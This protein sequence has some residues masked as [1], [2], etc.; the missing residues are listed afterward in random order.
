MPRTAL[1]LAGGL[2]TRIRHLAPN[3]PKPM[4]AVAG[5]PFLEWVIGYWRTQGVTRFAVSLGHMA[6]AAQSYLAMRPLDGMEIV[7]VHEPEPMGT[8]GAVRFAAARV[9][10]GDTFVTA[11]ADSLVVADTSPAWRLMEQEAAIDGVV[12]GVRVEDASRYGTLA[13]DGQGLLTEFREKAPGAGL[14]NAGVYFFRRRMLARFGDKTPLSMENDVFP[15][16]IR[17]G[18]RLHVLGV[19][20]P[21]LDIGTPESLARAGAFVTSW[22]TR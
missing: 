4:I 20:A 14:I 17:S 6:E 12:L 16:W 13:A 3:L 11:N 15:Q 1:L 5:K 22:L 2:G 8:G 10:L 9:D 18:A 7:T 21:F 19:E